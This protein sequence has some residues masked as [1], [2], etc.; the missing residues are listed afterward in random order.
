MR[1]R[2]RGSTVPRCATAIVVRIVFILIMSLGAMRTAAAVDAIEPGLW[3]ISTR[4]ATGLALGPP[5]P[6][7]K[8]LTPEQARDVVA[9][10]SPVVGT[11]NSECAPIERSFTD[12]KLKWHLVCKGQLDMDMSGEFNFDSS[13]HYTATL[14]SK[15]EMAGKTVVNTQSLIEAARVSDCPQGDPPR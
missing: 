9:T 4:T 15:A 1:F 5:Q 14:H 8:C 7:S 11:V 13:T 10:F 12:G 2:L 3:Q 6:S